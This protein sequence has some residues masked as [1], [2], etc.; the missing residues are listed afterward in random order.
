MT[1]SELKDLLRD[2][3]VTNSLKRDF[4]ALLIGI[5]LVDTLEQIR[6]EMITRM[7]LIVR[8]YEENDD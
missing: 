4:L 7:P 8:P 1:S 5:A 6:E 3:D 2:I